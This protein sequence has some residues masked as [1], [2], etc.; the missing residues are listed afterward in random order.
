[1][2][3]PFHDTTFLSAYILWQTTLAGIGA[4][5]DAAD[6][7]L[8]AWSAVLHVIE[9]YGLIPGVEAFL[10]TNTESLPSRVRSGITIVPSHYQAGVRF[11]SSPTGQLTYIR[12]LADLIDAIS[13]D[14]II[15]YE[16]YSSITYQVTKLGAAKGRTKHVILCNETSPFNRGLWSVFPLTRWMAIRTIQNADAFIALTELA[17]SSL[18]SAGTPS[19]KIHRVHPGVFPEDFESASHRTKIPGSP[20]KIGFIGALR[21]N[22]GIHTIIRAAKKIS[23]NDQGKVVFRIAGTGPLRP[24]VLSA[25]QS[26]KSLEYVGFIGDTEKTMFFQ[27]LDAF[28]YPCID[29]RLAGLVRWQEQTAYSVLEAMATGLPLIVTQSGALP[30]IVGRSDVVIPQGDA[31]SLVQKIGQ[32]IQCEDKREMMSSYF[33]RRARE[34]FDIR[35]TARSLRA[36]IDAL[37]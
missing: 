23:R 1:M 24:L 10:T 21:K 36:A 14:V 25:A 4:L 8:P 29:D 11:S 15:T 16:I 27:S 31:E 6:G 37:P 22:K 26:E 7:S 30:E 3:G 35:R 9:M 13:P 18:K 12:G 33:I 20:W 2:Q 5:V 17:K 28:V 32:L 34:N 19:A